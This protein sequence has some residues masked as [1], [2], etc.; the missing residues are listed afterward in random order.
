MR[1][2]S[3]FSETKFKLKKGDNLKE[4]LQERMKQYEEQY[5]STT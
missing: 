5:E 3:I 4:Y 2:I 1:R